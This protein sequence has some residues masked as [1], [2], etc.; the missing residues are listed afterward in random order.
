MLRRKKGIKTI[1]RKTNLRRFGLCWYPHPPG[2]VGGRQRL[3]PELLGE[4][5]EELV[6]G[7]VCQAP[8]SPL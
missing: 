8:G 4:L 5:P 2:I 1:R 6:P 3:L 7:E